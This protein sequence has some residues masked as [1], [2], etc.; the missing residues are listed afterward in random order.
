MLDLPDMD[1]VMPLL[2]FQSALVQPWT[3]AAPPLSPTDVSL[4][5]IQ[6][7]SSQSLTAHGLSEPVLPDSTSASVP[8]VLESWLPLSSLPAGLRPTLDPSQ[9][10]PLGLAALLEPVIAFAQTDAEVSETDRSESDGSESEAPEASPTAAVV[11]PVQLP[12]EPALET[13]AAIADVRVVPATE[14][15]LSPTVASLMA[16]TVSEAPLP[17]PA[18]TNAAR[19]QVWLQDQHIAD[20]ESLDQ[21]EAVAQQ[22][23]QW[24][25]VGLN[26]EEIL[27]VL[28]GRR[29]LVRINDD[30]VLPITQSMAESLG[31]SPEWVAVAI[32][33]NLRQALNIAR[34]DAGAVQMA[35][36]QLAPSPQKLGGTASWYGPYFHGRIT[37]TGE[38]FNQYDLTAAHK[39]LPFGTRLKVRNVNNG[40]TVVVRINDRGPY[41]GDRSLDLSK[42]AA[43]C[44][45]GEQVGLVNYEALILQDATTLDAA[46][47]ETLAMGLSQLDQN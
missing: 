41:I 9:L 22:I 5:P 11:T 27:P 16:C 13:W 35:F 46:G 14:D 24:H 43:Q 44:L 17:D 26:G 20:F 36:D 39:T 3:V 29:P 40:R 33:N 12:T 6:T 45:G 31:H 4:L 34:L 37:A 15:R 25:Q 47:D 1:A 19:Y 42:A 18:Q 28:E 10:T 7:L 8:A 23:R 32:A 38:T 21:A 2:P 30:T